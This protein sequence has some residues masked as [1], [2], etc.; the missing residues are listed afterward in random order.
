MSGVINFFKDS[1]D[2]YLDPISN[3]IYQVI[4]REPSIGRWRE[5]KPSDLKNFKPGPTEGT[6]FNPVTEEFCIGDPKD[7]TYIK[8]GLDIEKLAKYIFGST[9]IS[10]FLS[11]SSLLHGYDRSVIQWIKVGF[12]I[13]STIGIFNSYEREK[14]IILVFKLNAV[15]RF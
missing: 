6:F 13:G 9:F 11:I 10:G 3:I 1:I 7:A 14:K 5:L 12:V 2:L 15:P 4:W 8:G